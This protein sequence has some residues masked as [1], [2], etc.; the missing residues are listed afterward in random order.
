M[1]YFSFLDCETG[2]QIKIGANR[3][4]YLLIPAEFGG[5]HI[6]ESRYNGYGDF[7]MC[8]VYELV[9]YWNRTKLPE[10]LPHKPQLSEFGGLFPWSVNA[11]RKE[12]YSEEQIELENY[13]AQ[14]AYHLKALAR[15]R[16][17]CEMM[18][19]YAA[20]LSDLEMID[21]YDNDFLREIGVEI[22]GDDEP[23][24]RL[25]YPIKVTYSETAVYETSAP[26]KY[27]PLQGCD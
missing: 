20:G 24:A 4:V 27:D 11:L 15:W 21:K 22:A 12:G 7:S 14:T 8:D 25:P 10:L 6:R 26:S 13:K 2:E 5:G 17:T 16:V 23:N 19:D 18:N 3:P 1:G 9:A